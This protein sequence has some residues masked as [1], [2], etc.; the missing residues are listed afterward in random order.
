MFKRSVLCARCW[1]TLHSVWTNHEPWVVL[2]HDQKPGA[3]EKQI[4][5]SEWGGIRKT[6]PGA[7]AVSTTTGKPSSRPSP[8]QACMKKSLG[9]PTRLGHTSPR[10]GSNTL[11]TGNLPSVP[12]MSSSSP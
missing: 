6:H 4:R 3:V 7:S 8:R 9:F 10:N 5:R 1:S 2:R 11:S 12:K